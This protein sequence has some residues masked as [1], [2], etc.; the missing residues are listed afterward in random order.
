MTNSLSRLGGTGSSIANS[1]IETLPYMLSI[2]SS[3][4]L[5]MYWSSV[6]F[7]ELINL[8]MSRGPAGGHNGDYWPAHS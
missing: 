3:P 1:M 6:H 2:I 8:I 4:H 5:H 7:K